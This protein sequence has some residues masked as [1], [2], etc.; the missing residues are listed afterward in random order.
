MMLKMMLT[1]Q[2]KIVLKM[3][4]KMVL[5]MVLMVP[6]STSHISHKQLNII[7]HRK[8]SKTSIVEDG[9]DNCVE[10]CGVSADKHFTHFLQGADCH[11]AQQIEQNKH[12]AGN[13]DNDVEDDVKHGDNYIVEEEDDDSVEDGVNSAHKNFTHLS[14]AVDC[15]LRQRSKQTSMLLANKTMML[16]MTL[17]LAITR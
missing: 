11:S 2:L 17:M 13:K 9:D 5:T 7:L 8:V 14:Q 10:D 1:M 15:H 16:I 12:V 6:S 4:M 3:V